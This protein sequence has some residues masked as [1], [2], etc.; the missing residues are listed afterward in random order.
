AKSSVGESVPASA[1]LPL[2][3]A[4]IALARFDRRRAVGFDFF[5]VLF[6]RRLAQFVEID[7]LRGRRRRLF[8]GGFF[9][10]GL[11][12]SFFFRLCVAGRLGPA[13]FRRGRGAGS[14]RG[15]RSGGGQALAFEVAGLF[16]GRA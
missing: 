12:F 4:A 16:R 1:E 7:F 15:Q 5:L 11:F 10:F 2:D 8:G 9:R 3:R 14:R 6:A 13:R